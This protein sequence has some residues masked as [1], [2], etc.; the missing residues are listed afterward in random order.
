MSLMEIKEPLEP[1]ISS[2]N[3]YF[4]APSSLNIGSEQPLSEVLI[5]RRKTILA[6]H[7]GVCVQPTAVA[8]KV[9]IPLYILF[10]SSLPGSMMSLK[11]T[12]PEGVTVT[13]SGGR[14]VPSNSH[15]LSNVHS[16]P[17]LGLESS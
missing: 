15:A 10:S 6:V 9:N 8:L 4:S 5:P 11:V 14:G 13:A 3:A 12:L 17:T 7:F 2:D 1:W 16:T